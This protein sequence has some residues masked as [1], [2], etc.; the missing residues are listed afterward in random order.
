[1]FQFI[2][3]LDCLLSC[4]M[5][6]VHDFFYRTDDIGVAVL[7]LPTVLDRKAHTIQ[8][9][10]IQQLGVPGHLLEQISLDQCLRHTVKAVS[11][12]FQ[13]FEIRVLH[14]NSSPPVGL[15]LH[16]WK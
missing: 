12:C 2:Q 11:V 13:T 8:Q 16:Y 9:H 15:D 5:D 10:S 4:T 6:R 14:V 1:M 7:V 3:Q